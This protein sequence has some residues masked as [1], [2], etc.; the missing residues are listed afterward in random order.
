MHKSQANQNILNS[1]SGT[2]QP[3]DGLG[4]SPLAMPA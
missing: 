3:I 4:L 2:T 1:E